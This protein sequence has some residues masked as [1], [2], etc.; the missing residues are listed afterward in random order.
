MCYFLKTFGGKMS[1]FDKIKNKD[2]EKK[3]SLFAKLTEEKKGVQSSVFDKLKQPEIIIQPKD[4]NTGSISGK[5]LAKNNVAIPYY[6]SQT[7]IYAPRS[8]SG[9]EDRNISIPIWS[10]GKTSVSYQGPE[11]DTKIDYKLMSI[12]LKA[13]DQLPAEKHVVRLRYK[14]T[15]KA[16]GLNPHHPDSRKKF[17]SSI[18]RHLSGKF[19]FSMDNEKEGFWKPLFD[20]EKT[21]FSY[22]RNTLIIQ[23]NDIVPK[24]FNYGRKE[25]F[26]IEDMLISFSIKDSYA[27]KLYSYYES[28]KVPFGIKIST[29]LR[30][31]DHPLGDDEKPSNNQ[32]ATVKKA[33]TELVKIGFLKT[34]SLQEDKDKR[35][36]LVII[37]KVEREA[38]NICNS[39][40]FKDNF[41][42]N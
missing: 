36:P 11:L 17:H 28:N 20:S 4:E 30:I 23:L 25:T 40:E 9:R 15:M 19:F 7:A 24:L 1:L 18:E 37:E 39:I 14:E 3:P 35:D 34:W 6:L 26:S 41:L 27:A 22:T 42:D 5:V 12:V 13:R 29:I 10:Q 16:L 2:E 33:L 21:I 38:R 31:C 32:R 8:S